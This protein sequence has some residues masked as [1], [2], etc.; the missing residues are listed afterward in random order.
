MLLY[1]ITVE[2][3]LTLP[4]SDRCIKNVA[5]V[6]RI[7]GVKTPSYIS[8]SSITLHTVVVDWIAAD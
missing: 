1:I 7:Y 3:T 2:E 8:L 5:A 6:V 4:A